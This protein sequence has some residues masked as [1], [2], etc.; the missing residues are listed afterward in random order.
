MVFDNKCGGIGGQ[1]YTKINN[2]FFN[3]DIND[4]KQHPDLNYAIE[5]N[6]ENMLNV[7]KKWYKQIK[8][9]NLINDEQI[10]EL[11]KIGRAHV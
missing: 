7:S 4:F 8:E 9:F 10:K 5:H 1:G 2:Y 6:N 3:C 11:I